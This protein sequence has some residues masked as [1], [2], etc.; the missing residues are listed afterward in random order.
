VDK[1]T[2][3]IFLA[4]AMASTTV[5]AETKFVEEPLK[6]VA[7]SYDDAL[8]D[9][10]ADPRSPP[11]YSIRLREN[12]IVFG[13]VEIPL[14]TSVKEPSRLLDEI[15]SGLRHEFN[16][17]VSDGLDAIVN[18]K[19]WTCRSFQMSHKSDG[20][21]GLVRECVFIGDRYFNRMTIIVPQGLTESSESQLNSVILS[22]KSV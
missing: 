20:R 14:S 18:P 9:S 2:R 15:E 13:I 3:C 6:Q 10:H 19:D 11:N 8:W 17:S 1:T 12:G 22:L 16:A 7:F 5:V 4:L 21:T